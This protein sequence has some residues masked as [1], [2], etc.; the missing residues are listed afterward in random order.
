M[1][2]KPTIPRIGMFA[3]IRN[4]RGVVSAVEA[5][6]DDTGRLHLVH[7][8]YKDD[9]L[10]HEEQLLWE[11][12]PR[13]RLLEPTALPSATESDSMEG[14]DFDALLRAAR[15]TAARPYLDPDGKGPVER[16]PVSSPFHG[17]VQVK[18][19]R[20]E[21]I[22]WE[23]SERPFETVEE[24]V[25]RTGLNENTLT[26][27]AE[28]G[29]LSPL[30][31]NR[32]NALWAVRGATRLPEADME[33]EVTEGS[34]GFEELDAFETI[35]W[36]L[37]T[38]P[39]S[40]RGH[41]LGPLREE[42]KARKLPDAAT[43][44]TLRDGQRVRYAGMAICRQRPSTASGVLFMTL[45]DETGFVNIV[46]RSKVYEE[47]RVLIK[48]SHFIGVTGKLQVKDEVVHLIADSFWKPPLLVRPESGGSHDFR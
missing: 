9:Q 33:L 32:R 44:S 2:A 10:P 41:P 45:E 11:L 18:D 13:G 30:E 21:R 40:A 31:K 35:S 6:D 14:E 3:T 36:N 8:E 34:P 38:T 15:W 22:A 46:A 1:T 7:L 25:E 4:R 12:E 39:H 16:L 26:R 17:A 37:A 29:A 42:L 5:F 27:L 19:Y 20:W 23:R 47:H 28:T 24:L 48:S 43:V